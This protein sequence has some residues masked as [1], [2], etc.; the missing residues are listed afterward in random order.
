MSSTESIAFNTLPEFTSDEVKR[1]IYDKTLGILIGKGMSFNNDELKKIGNRFGKEFTEKDIMRSIHKWLYDKKQE[2][3]IEIGTYGADY[4]K[5]KDDG[6]IV[7][8]AMYEMAYQMNCEM[9][10]VAHP[11]NFGSK[12]KYIGNNSKGLLRTDGQG[13]GG[14]KNDPS[15][16]SGAT[17]TTIEFMTHAK[18]IYLLVVSGGK[19]T[20][21]ELEVYKKMDNVEII[22]LNLYLDSPGEIMANNLEIK[23]EDLILI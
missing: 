14:Y 18:K 11:D 21:Q 15:N 16:T 9:I 2:L 12:N 17:K 23:M 3:G 20:A 13:W 5:I 7:G 4:I 19:T 8:S 6:S 10:A 22:M 1:K